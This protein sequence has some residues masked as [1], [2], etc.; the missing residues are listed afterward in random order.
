MFIGF[1]TNEQTNE[2][3][4]MTENKMKVKS[5]K[6]RVGQCVSAESAMHIYKSTKKINKNYICT[7]RKR[8]MKNSR[9][10]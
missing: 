7:N 3:I 2:T 9:K 8:E 4:P 5:I 1:A 10:K 6:T